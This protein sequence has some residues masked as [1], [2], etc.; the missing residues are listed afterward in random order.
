MTKVKVC[1]ITRLED[2]RKAV[3]AGADALGFV[4][5]SQSPRYIH[6]DT[7]RTIID[8]VA[9]F[10]TPVGVFV[11][12]TA[13]TIRRII[14]TSRVQVIQLHGEEPPEFCGQFAAKV[15]KAFRVRERTDIRKMLSGYHVDAFL[16]DAYCPDAPGG[17]GRTFSWDVAIEAKRYGPVIL[18]G[19]LTPWNVA[20]AIKLVAPYAVDVSSGVE[21]RPGRKDEARI[22]AFLQRVRQCNQ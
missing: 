14:K 13:S 3:D 5:Y 22:I 6:P 17:T 20:D 19:G 1:G 4:F 21:S 8:Q 11:N 9:P 15:I 7:A 2:A 18:A 16:L 12:A 10:V